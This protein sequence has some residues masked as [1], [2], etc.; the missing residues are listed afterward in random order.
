M[1]ERRG[2]VEAPK[3]RRRRAAKSVEK[4]K[5][6]NLPTSPLA[7]HTQRY[8]ARPLAHVSVHS[9]VSLSKTLSSLLYNAFLWDAL[10]R[11]HSDLADTVSVF[12]R[13]KRE[14]GAPIRYTCPPLVKACTSANGVREG[15]AFLGSAVR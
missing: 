3:I 11:G 9:L 2:D 7:H 4:L 10:I 13:M 15:R 12:V 6:C 5:P 8:T 14:E 1:V